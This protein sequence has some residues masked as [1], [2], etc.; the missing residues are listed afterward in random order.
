MKEIVVYLAFLEMPRIG[1]NYKDDNNNIYQL[2]S[3]K[4]LRTL[5][6]KFTWDMQN[7][8]YVGYYRDMNFIF[9]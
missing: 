3:D 8:N 6:R 1:L 2:R 9:F 4:D 5:I 7:F